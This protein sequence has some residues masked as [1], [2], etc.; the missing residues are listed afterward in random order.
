[1]TQ[2]DSP[3]QESTLRPRV[4]SA[5]VN[6]LVRLSNEPIRELTDAA[7]LDGNDYAETSEVGAVL[8]GSVSVVTGGAGFGSGL[9]TTSGAWENGGSRADG[10]KSASDDGFGEHFD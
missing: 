2:D 8:G 6:Q 5:T 1:M 9:V 7:K 4:T 10:S 3:Q